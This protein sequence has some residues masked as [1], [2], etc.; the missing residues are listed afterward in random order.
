[1]SD[2]IQFNEKL[3]FSWSHIIAALA[4]VAIAYFT[5][6]GTVYLLKGQFLRSGLI[7]AAITLI[8]GLLFFIPQQLKAT[9]RRFDKRIKWE[10]AFI[11]ASPAAPGFPM[12]TK[13]TNRSR[14]SGL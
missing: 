4:L 12:K 6:V 11:F 14:C 2:N 13:N 8:I 5:F 1:M 10:R 3:K 9:E 7:T